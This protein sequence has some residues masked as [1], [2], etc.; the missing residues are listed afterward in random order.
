MREQIKPEIAMS[1]SFNKRKEKPLYS[2]DLYWTE[3]SVR[4]LTGREQNRK[5]KYGGNN[6][7]SES[8][9]LR[10]QCVTGIVF[11]NNDRNISGLDNELFFL[12]N[13]LNGE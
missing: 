3:E 12:A 5:Q 4:Y 8:A 7:V 13:D 2:K 9:F 10:S 1:A 11:V 6:E